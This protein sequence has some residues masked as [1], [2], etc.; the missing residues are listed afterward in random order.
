MLPVKGQNDNVVDP[1]VVSSDEF[2]DATSRLS[3][4]VEAYGVTV[5]PESNEL[6]TGSY[7][8]V[9]PA[10]RLFDN[11]SGNHTYSRPIRRCGS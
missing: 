2:E 4:R 10:G 5:V 9:D 7:V 6:M 3:R 1:F 11:V 8:M